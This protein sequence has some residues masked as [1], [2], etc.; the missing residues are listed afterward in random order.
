M[1]SA[2]SSWWHKSIKYQSTHRATL[3][4]RNN[5]NNKNIIIINN[6]SQNSWNVE[7]NVATAHF[8]TII[9]TINHVKLGIKMDI[10][11]LFTF[12]LILKKKCLSGTYS[13]NCSEQILVHGLPHA[14]KTSFA[15]EEFKAWAQHSYSGQWI[16]YF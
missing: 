10:L 5:I 12:C 13:S 7:W 14:W 4:F 3:G 2:A 16:E 6:I 1:C 11:N 8:K 9:V 15:E